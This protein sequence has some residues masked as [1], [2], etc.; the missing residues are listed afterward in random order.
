MKAALASITP[1]Q[2]RTTCVCR[3]VQVYMGVDVFGRGSYGGG[4]VRSRRLL[5]AALLACGSLHDTAQ[6]RIWPLGPAA[7]HSRQLRGRG[8][9]SHSRHR[10]QDNCPAALSAARSRGL[11]AALFA[12]GWVW[13]EFDRQTFEPRQEAFWAAVRPRHAARSALCTT[14]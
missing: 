11:S 2:L 1:Q 10:P 12:P 4:K 5:T 7:L 14:A 9:D 3:C 8:S 6:P 13:E